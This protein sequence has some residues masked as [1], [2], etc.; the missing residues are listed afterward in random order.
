MCCSQDGLLAASRR[1]RGG[2]AIGS[3]NVQA[4]AGEWP[5][6]AAHCCEIVVGDW[7][8]LRCSASF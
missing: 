1:S 6:F 2:T 8:E 3:V 5:Y 4:E 7:V